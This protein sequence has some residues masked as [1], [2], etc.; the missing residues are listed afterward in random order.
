[1]MHHRFRSIPLRNLLIVP[2]ILQIFGTVALIGYLSFRNG[3]SAVNNLALQLREEV[4]DR[5]DQHL[6][7]YM[8][9]PPK[10]CQTIVDAV[11][12]NNI[13]LTRISE[14]VAKRLGYFFWQQVQTH[15]IGYVSFGSEKGE[16]I[17]AGLDIPSER[18]SIEYL[19]P[20][21]YLNTKV[22]VYYTDDQGR[23]SELADIPTDYPFQQ[24]PWYAQDHS[25]PFW[26][27]IYA[28]ELPPYSL[29]ISFS[30]PLYNQNH[31]FIGI[32]SI[33]QRLEQISIFLNQLKPS[34]SGQIFLM[35]RNG[36]LIASSSRQEPFQVINGKPMR[37]Q[38]TDFSDPLIQETAKYLKQKFGDFNQ[39][40]QNQS[41]EFSFNDQRHFLQVGEWQDHWGL[42]W[43]VVIV[44]P[45]S[46]FMAEIKTNRDTTLLLC[47]GALGVATIL[48]V[49]TTHW[50]M[51]PIL[52]L[53]EASEGLAKGQFN[54]TIEVHGINELE[55]LAR[56]FNQMAKQ[57]QDSFLILEDRVAERTI[58]LQKAKEMADRANQ[59][60]SE[61]LANMSHEL[62]TP[63]NGILGD[64]QILERSKTLLDKDHRAIR[65]IHQCGTHLLTLINDVLDLAKIEARRVDL[66]PSFTHLLPL[67]Q[68]V[69]EICKIRAEQKEIE[70]IYQPSNDLP[71]VVMVDAK[72]L[73]QVLINLLGNA[74]KFT[75]RG[76]VNFRVEVLDQSNA[77]V[78]LLFRV[79]DTGVGI[80]EADFAKLFQAFE[81]VGDHQKQTEGTGLGLSIS[82]CVVSLMGSK[83]Q[84]KSQLGQ[85]S[86]FFFQVQLPFIKN[87]KQQE[88]TVERYEHIMGY[89][90]D[91]RS[92]LV[93][94]DRWENCAVIQNLLEPLG[95]ELIQAENGQVGLEKLVSFQP[96]LVITDLAMPVMNGF[97]LLKQIR[98]SEALKKTLVIASS[99]SI[100]QTDQEIALGQGA[101]AFLLKPVEARALLDLLAEYLKLE[102]IFDSTHNSTYNSTHESKHESTHESRLGNPEPTKVS[103]S[104]LVLPPAEVLQDLLKLAGQ[105]YV[106]ALQEK[107]EAL[108]NEDQKY[109]PFTDPILELI[110]NFDLE[111]VEKLLREYL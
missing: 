108:K 62:R 65:I 41:L 47:L 94:D 57:L 39:I 97:T 50:I 15:D 34:P 75:D 51:R 17:A 101:D 79:I 11:A 100:T 5:I 49:Y 85:G 93:I 10:L 56:S 1:M 106:R 8:T 16:Y 14:V 110:T 66:T 21:Y 89:K 42:D 111:E 30:K 69:V 78:T 27:A 77:E 18:I 76:F 36:L 67:L 64:A 7:S 28:W 104:E 54:Q 44:I 74:I 87:W 91:R 58:E 61:F 45:E 95:F 33:D 81:Q 86:E 63:L 88:K 73:R 40:H 92:I 102:W 37:E 105:G 46:D 24:E 38:V 19:L 9:V 60:K 2:F 13:D 68:T 103:E 26:T 12:L 48:G 3:Q 80:A 90:G 6:N 25:K 43:L 71:K 35:E 23:I 55:A 31:Q 84:V 98:E 96:D 29:S 32:I 107:I 20:A 4:S 53:Q 72:R 82:Q 70:L 109:R 22:Y 83:I 99:A 59:A 52:Q